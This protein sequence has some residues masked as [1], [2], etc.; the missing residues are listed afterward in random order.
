[1]RIRSVVVE[2]GREPRLESDNPDLS[3]VWLDDGLIRW[4]NVEGATREDLERLFQPLAPEGPVLAGHITG[5]QW[6]EVFDREHCY[7]AFLAAPTAWLEHET[8]FHIVLLPQTICTLHPTEIPSTDDFMQRCWFDRP[9]PDSTVD[10]VMLHVI[11]GYI[12]EEITEFYRVRFQVEEHAEG[13]RRG[14]A[15]FTVEDLEELMTRCHHMATAFFEHQTLL[16]GIGFSRSRAF[17]LGSHSHLYSQA[18]RAIGNL[19][20][21]VQ[22]IQH[23]LA[24]L[25]QQHVMDQQE[26][27]NSRVR[28]LTIIS[29][30]FLPLT[31][32]AG[33]YGMNFENMPELDE[34][35]AYFIVLIAMV[36]VAFGMLGFFYWKGWFR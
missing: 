5:D 11:Q 29:A 9:G 18:V 7:A 30:I 19:R 10:A 36:S 20:E 1:M 21:G 22:Q 4:V 8:W 33:I 2:A 14:D 35:N 27:F 12:E 6:F 16:Q 23:R 3:S 26:Q 32:I 17:S 15:A 25:Q 31:L 24:E 28:V 13:L 34:S